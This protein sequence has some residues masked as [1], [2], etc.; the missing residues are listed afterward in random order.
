[1][2][3]KVGKLSGHI[4]QMFGYHRVLACELKQPHQIPSH[5]HAEGRL[6]LMVH[7]ALDK[8]ISQ[9]LFLASGDHCMKLREEMHE[10]YV[11]R[12]RPGLLDNQSKVLKIVHNLFSR[13]LSVV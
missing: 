12:N 9:I 1:M 13:V 3:Y 11:G 6:D 5:L 2:Q 10:F 4:P 8:P 7:T